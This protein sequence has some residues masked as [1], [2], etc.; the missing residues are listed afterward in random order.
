LK[1]I[2]GDNE[3]GWDGQE[4]AKFAATGEALNMVLEIIRTQIQEEIGV[5]EG[6]GG[7]LDK[8]RFEECIDGTCGA[9]TYNTEEIIIKVW[10]N[11]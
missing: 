8:K 3:P 7:S 9:T 6:P 4:R 1:S 10:K 11:E 2:T 5:G